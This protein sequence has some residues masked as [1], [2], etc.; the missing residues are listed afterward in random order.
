MV[1]FHHFPYF[2]NHGHVVHVMNNHRSSRSGGSGRTGRTGRRKVGDEV[3]V[4]APEGFQMADA[5][6][7]MYHGHGQ[8]GHRAVKMWCCEA[9]KMDKVETGG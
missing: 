9:L 4:S 5:N 1:R 7:C 8:N 2:Y 3:N 6:G